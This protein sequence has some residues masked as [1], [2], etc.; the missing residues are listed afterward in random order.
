MKTDDKILV[1]RQVLLD[2]IAAAEMAREYL[3][4]KTSGTDQFALD[5]RRTLYNALPPAVATTG[6]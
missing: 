6:N 5:T 2:L 3:A 4:N 1:E